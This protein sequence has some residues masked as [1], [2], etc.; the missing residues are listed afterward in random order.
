MDTHEAVK[1]TVKLS[2]DDPVQKFAERIFKRI[3]QIV[4]LAIALIMGVTVATAATAATAGV[5]LHK[6][7]QTAECATDWHKH[8]TEQLIMS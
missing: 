5:L 6:K 7:I 2:C 1:S 4:G 8:P 3:H